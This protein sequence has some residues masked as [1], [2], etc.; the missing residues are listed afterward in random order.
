MG[1]VCVIGVRLHFISL[2]YGLPWCL[3]RLRIH[4][5][6]R[7]HKGRRF[8]PWVRKIPWRG[9]RKS[10]PVFLPENSHGQR[11]LAGDSPKSRKESD[12][13]E[14]LNTQHNAHVVIDTVD[15]SS[16]KPPICLVHW[17]WYFSIFGSILLVSFLK[18]V[19]SSLISVLYGLKN[20]SLL[21]LPRHPPEF[22]TPT[23]YHLLSICTWK[24]PACYKRRLSKAKL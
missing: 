18:A 22:Q 19:P 11:N 7:R 3:S 13:T 15:L 14:Q 8:D 24:S 1:Y 12:I 6:C 20:P 4:L 2:L 16:L 17:C 21:F 10:I 23:P 9:K 5:Q